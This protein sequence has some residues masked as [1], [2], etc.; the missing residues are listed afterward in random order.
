MT[1]P[2]GFEPFYIY[3]ITIALAFAAL[4]VIG[5]VKGIRTYVRLPKPIRRRLLLGVLK[6]RYTLYLILIAVLA[7]VA[8]TLVVLQLRL[9]S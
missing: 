4:A 3:R 6:G 8:I 1:L 2:V 9:R 7:V 5:L